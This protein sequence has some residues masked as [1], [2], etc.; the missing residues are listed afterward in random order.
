MRMPIEVDDD[1]HTIRI[2]SGPRLIG[3]T[4]PWAWGALVDWAATTVDGG[5]TEEGAI[6]EGYLLF[7]PWN[8]VLL[9][10][11]ISDFIH[12]GDENDLLR[13]SFLVGGT[14]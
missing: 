3:S 7:R 6:I 13:T 4:A 5:H 12:V 9:G 14:F 2:G 10:V 8:H 1:V 11:Q